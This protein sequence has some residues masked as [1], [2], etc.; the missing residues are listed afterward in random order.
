MFLK[1]LR[2]K[3]LQGVRLKNMCTQVNDLLSFS[4]MQD[5]KFC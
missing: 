1:S 4:A 3:E 5:D 2:Y